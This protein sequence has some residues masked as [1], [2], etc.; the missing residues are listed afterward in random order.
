MVT[1]LGVFFYILPYLQRRV[2]RAEAAF[3]TDVTTRWL[4]AHWLRAVANLA[5]AGY[6]RSRWRLTRCFF[7][8]DSTGDSRD[9]FWV[10]GRHFSRTFF[11]LGD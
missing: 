11:R 4:W 7:A 5:V 9:T 2:A 3:A 1:A 10:R 8:S 6:H